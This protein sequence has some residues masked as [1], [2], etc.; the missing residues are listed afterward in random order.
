[1]IMAALPELS[2]GLPGSRNSGTELFDK[3]W[4]AGTIRRQS[5]AEVMQAEARST[6]TAWR[7]SRRTIGEDQLRCSV[8]ASSSCNPDG[9]KD[10]QSFRGE[11]CGTDQPA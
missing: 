1:M 6:L 2:P 5:S 8:G 3:S 7:K 10:W 9:L 4:Y 11:S